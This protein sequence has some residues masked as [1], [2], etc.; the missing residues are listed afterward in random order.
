[1]KFHSEW[2][3]LFVFVNCITF[4][5]C[6]DKEEGRRSGY[7]TDPPS[8]EKIVETNKIRKEYGI[9]QI[10]KSWIFNY[11]E[12]GIERWK[13]ERGFPC[14]R[15]RYD[16]YYEQILSEHDFY[17]TGRTFPCLDPDG[18]ISSEHLT[19]AYD[20]TRGRFAVVP[21]TDNNDIIRIIDPLR[22]HVIEFGYIGKTNEE[23]LEVA[24][25]ILKMWGLERL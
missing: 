4:S 13:D 10:K 19:I 22:E 24:D 5:G 20:Y 14:K 23:A 3:I 25:E 8:N 16:K 6:S 17:Y 2:I 9:R 18:G 15:V 12:F 7:S 11:R 1:M 21:T